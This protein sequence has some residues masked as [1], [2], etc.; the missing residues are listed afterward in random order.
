M[1]TTMEFFPT[2]HISGNQK[3]TGWRAYFEYQSKGREVSGRW[4]YS[5]PQCECGSLDK[6][7]HPWPRFY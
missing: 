2:Y 7:C 3:G 5:N 4:F 6:I 1:K